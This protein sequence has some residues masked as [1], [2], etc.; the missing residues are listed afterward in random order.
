MN[1]VG[2]KINSAEKIIQILKNKAKI[3]SK[4][5]KINE[6]RKKFLQTKDLD[7]KYFLK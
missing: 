1:K 6:F 2:W 7:L 4:I 5:K 3:D